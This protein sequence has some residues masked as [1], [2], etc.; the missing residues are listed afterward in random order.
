MSQQTS[1]FI[2]FYRISVHGL[3]A[4]GFFALLA[5]GHLPQTSW[6]IVGVV[7]P[8]A[9]L[10]RSLGIPVPYVLK[11]LLG[12]AGAGAVLIDLG[13]LSAGMEPVRYVALV[14]FYLQL[15]LLALPESDLGY[16]AAA[17][18]SFLQLV[19]AASLTTSIVFL[20]VSLFYVVTA[21]WVLVLFQIKEGTDRVSTYAENQWRGL[22][23][24][25]L[26]AGT[27]AVAAVV[28]GLTGLFFFIIPR[29]GAGYFFSRNA[30]APVVSGFSEEVRLG[31]LGE[32]KQSNDV[33][34]R[35]V[36]PGRTEAPPSGVYW[37]G[38]ALDTYDGRVW[39]HSREHQNQLTPDQQGFND[40]R[41]F[42][43]LG[44]SRESTGSDLVQEIFLS[45][46]HTSVLFGAPRIITVKGK[47]TKL[48]VDH[49]ASVRA[50]FPA[51]SSFYYRVLSRLVDV[52]PAVLRASGRRYPAHIRQTHLQLP[53]GVDRIARAARQVTAGASN[54][55]DE[56]RALERFLKTQY[57]YSLDLKGVDGENPLEDFLL[58]RKSGHCEFFASALAIMLRT[59]GVPAR[60]VNGYQQGEWNDVGNY[61]IVRKSDAHSW[62]EVYFHR[63]GWIAFNPTPEAGLAI[64]EV[65]GSSFT[66]LRMAWDSARM[67]W[68][69]SVIEY[70]LVDQIDQLR[71]MGRRM[72]G[73]KQGAG[74]SY[75]YFMEALQ[76]LASG[77]E[78]RRGVAWQ[79]RFWLLGALIVILL[80]GARLLVRRAGLIDSAP[81]TGKDPL[82][83]LTRLMAILGRR[84]FHRMPGQTPR[85]LVDRVQTEEGQVWRPAATVTDLYYRA[86]FSS[87]P[88]K[89]EESEE[90]W[91]LLDE[92]EGN[93]NE[94]RNPAE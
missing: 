49:N 85:E 86:R 50:E 58:R 79:A 48:S 71:K 78:G 28:F 32:I 34:M 75:G 62:V 92:L 3:I 14:M 19:C 51:F 7:L 46:S 70:H 60:V 67:F 12:S 54:P 39:R 76:S 72:R 9:L 16:R 74:A 77:E 33:A 66:R 45:S 30:D 87:R 8:A 47:F 21:T 5:T 84:G 40:R 94:D 91:R 18:V 37:R 1:H 11:L 57:A 42:V 53:S 17:V 52:P 29:Y 13:L 43:A 55:Y 22:L 69:R 73:L 38:I 61:L 41:Y 56:A 20:V 93:L 88:L 4:A 36:L 68:K 59:L 26:L 10:V 89:P 82:E 27:A 25:R 44:R 81:R 90:A 6:G 80:P 83:F 31:D 2:H 24:L 35:V 64:H 63:H 23:S 15:G 65:D